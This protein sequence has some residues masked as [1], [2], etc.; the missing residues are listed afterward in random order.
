[1]YLND[2]HKNVTSDCLE[3][4]GK[5]QTRLSAL[6]SSWKMLPMLWAGPALQTQTW[7]DTLMLSTPADSGATA[8]KD[9]LQALES[10][11]GL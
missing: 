11:P 1:M 4:L 10:F 5:A 8:A 2:G 6:N 9:M 3:T 7:T